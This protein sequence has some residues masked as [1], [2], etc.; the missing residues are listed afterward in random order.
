MNEYEN[1]RNEK[2]GLWLVISVPLGAS[3]ASED[4]IAICS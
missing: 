3:L 2:H 1:A 4:R